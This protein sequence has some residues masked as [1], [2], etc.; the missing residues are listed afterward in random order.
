[1]LLHLIWPLKTN[2]VKYVWGDKWGDKNITP[3]KTQQIKAEIQ[4]QR[5]PQAG[6]LMLTKT[7]N[8]IYPTAVGS[9]NSQSGQDYRLACLSAALSMLHAS[10]ARSAT[11]CVMSTIKAIRPPK[12]HHRFNVH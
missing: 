1:M 12:A 10:G 2:H 6:F 4:K 7:T 9:L 11:N 5:R 8:Q 3:H